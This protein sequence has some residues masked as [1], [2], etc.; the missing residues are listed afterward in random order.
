V[1]A[2]ATKLRIGSLDCGKLMRTI[3]IVLKL[4]RRLG[5]GGLQFGFGIVQSGLCFGQPF[6]GIENA[7]QLAAAGGDV[8]CEAI[9]GGGALSGLGREYRIFANA[10]LLDDERLWLRTPS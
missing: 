4:E 6:L 1:V 5:D 10:F 9:G 7:L 3:G 8:Y 2:H